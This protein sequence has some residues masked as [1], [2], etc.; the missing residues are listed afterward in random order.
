MRGRALG[1]RDR[2]P[3]GDELLRRHC[4]SVQRFAQIAN[5]R[6]RCAIAGVVKLNTVHLTRG[7]APPLSP[8][9]SYTVGR[10]PG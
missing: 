3:L 8:R 1:E 5:V 7:C 10:G 4:G 2:L 6:V 9:C